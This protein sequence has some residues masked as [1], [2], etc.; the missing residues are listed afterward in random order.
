MSTGV[1]FTVHDL[2]LFPERLDGTRYEIVDGEL[3]V[4]KAPHWHHQYTSGRITRAFHDWDPD[5]RHGILIHTPGVIFSPEDAV[6]PDVIWVSRARWARLADPDGKFYAAPDL[7]IELLSAGAENERRDR[8]A[9]LKLY[10]VRGVRE[11]WIVDWRSAM[12]SVFRRGP[13]AQLHAA[14][15]LGPDD[16]LTSPLL[17]GFSAQV[18]ALCSAPA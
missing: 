3:F 11:Y 12:V 7:V 10:S 1:R 15:T 18:S 4:S 9:K 6:I 16:G 14:A 13:D 2:E 8:D 17:P 5:E